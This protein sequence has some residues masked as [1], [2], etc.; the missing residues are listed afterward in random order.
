[1]KRN[2]LLVLAVALS[3]SAPAWA[4]RPFGQFGGKVGG[5]NS[6][7]G[8]LPLYGW[9]LDDDGV[10]GIDILVDGVVDGRANYGRTRPQ[11]TKKYPNYPD[12]QHP[13]WVY[14]L[15]TT[16]Y[17]NGLHTITARVLSETGELV[18]LKP[19]RFQFGNVTHALIPFGHIEFPKHQAEMRGHCNL[20][21]PNR[22]WSIVSGYA[23]D[24]GVQVADTGVG[25]VELLLDG[26]LYANS[27][28]D[29]FRL[30]DF[31]LPV[32]C[33]GQRRQD[34]V[35][36]FPHL[37]DAPHSGFRFALDV[38]DLITFF[39]Y[40]EGSH[41]LT[42]RAGD[43]YE[44]I[45]TVDEVIVTFSC[46]DID[47]VDDE[48][49]IGDIEQ[50]L[51]GNMFSGIMQLRGWALDWE[52]VQSVQV[53]VDGFIVGTASYGHARPIITPVYPGYPNAPA[54][55]WEHSF[56]TRIF[57]N[58]EHFLE[59]VV[60]DFLGNTTYIGRRRFVITNPR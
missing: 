49:S 26:A 9:A 13:G 36:I 10:E 50:P 45:S 6:G 52:G 32:N 43:V 24:S 57:S 7:A 55:G 11:V 37:K 20:A 31:N 8:L 56:D 27:N 48:E 5:G 19:L 46:D 14:Q 16:H 33:Y 30:T 58:G 60:T 15:D 1:M 39:G 17:L 42:I 34:L 22:R 47:P 25:Y 23:L 53:L 44:Q 12:S 41:R 3:I 51:D 2:I 18:N 38:G 40:S 59:V 21:D 54:P 28:R 29:C 4:A 35:P